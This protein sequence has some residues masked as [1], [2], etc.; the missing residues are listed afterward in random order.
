[1]P[2]D[3]NLN[4][5][6]YFDDYDETKNFHRILIKPT[7][8]VQARELNQIQS[9]LQNQIERFGNSI[10]KDGAVINGCN[11]SF[12]PELNYVRLMDHTTARY[13]ANNEVIGTDELIDV[14]DYIGKVV[15]CPDTGLT[16]RILT[17]KSGTQQNFPYTNRFYI[18]YMNSGLRAGEQV[19][20]FG[21]GDVLDIY[22]NPYTVGRKLAT[23][24]ALDNSF[25]PSLSGSW[26]AGTGYGVASGEGLIYQKGFFIRS[27]PQTLV[28]SDTVNPGNTVVGFVTNEYIIDSNQ[29][30]TLF[31]NALGYQNENA[32][33]ADRMKLVANLTYISADDLS[34][35]AN[36]TSII[37]YVAG[38]PVIENPDQ[39]YSQIGDEM[40][41]RSSETNG[42]FVIKPFNVD[43][44]YGSA[45]YLIAKV[46]AGSGYS[47]GS[48]VE[49]LK[50]TPV[51]I[52]R[53]TD[54][55]TSDAQL[56]T[57]NYGNYVIVNEYAG[58]F[59]FTKLE[60]V[61]IYDAPQQAV[62]KKSF[63]NSAV[64][65]NQ[66]GVANMRAIQFLTG[67]EGTPT[68]QHEVYL[69]N[70]RMNPGKSFSLNGK[71]LVFNANG[72]KG[73]ADLVSSDVLN[74][75]RRTMIW[76]FGN[77]AV[78]NLKD[79]HNNINTQYVFRQKSTSTL[80]SNGTISLTLTTA[81][82]GG[83]N[84]FP[85]GTG[86]TLGD[87]L[88]ND[89]VVV[90]LA[91][92][93][94][95][96]IGNVSVTAATTQI[97]G[98][99]SGKPFSSMF[100]VGDYVRVASDIRRVIG[101]DANNL[102]VDSGF[103]ATNSAA[104]YTRYIQA[105]YTFPFNDSMVGSRTIQINSE[106]QATLS[107][108]TS[109]AGA[110][111]GTIPVAVYH[112][113]L[114]S[115]MI[116]VKKNI[117]KNY[118]VKIDTATHT[119]GANG[120]WSMG[121]TDVHELKN[122]FVTSGNTFIASGNDLLSLFN[123]D[124]GQQD[125]H[126]DYA[127]LYLK[128]G[129]S[130]PANSKLTVVADIFQTDTTQ[131][132]GFYSIDSYPIDDANTANTTAITT[133]NLPMYV[134]STG[135]A[136]ALRDSIDCRPQKI[137]V[138]NYA[139]LTSLN[140]ASTNPVPTQT[141]AT[142]TV[143]TYVPAPDQNFETDLTYYVGRKDIVYFS[144][145]GFV[146]VKEGVVNEFPQTPA[147]PDDGMGICVIQIPPF[148]SL[149]SEENAA[150]SAKNKLVYN[151]IRDTS[152]GVSVS[153]ITNKRYRMQDIGTID[154]RVSRLEYYQALN[155]LEQATTSLQV[156]DAQGLDRFKNGIFVD[157]FTNFSLG[158]VGNPE[159]K[160][161][162]DSNKG[163][164]RPFYN[165][166]RPELELATSLSSGVVRTG[167]LVTLPYQNVFYTG[168]PYATNLRN[169]ASVQ[170][171]WTGSMTLFPSYGHNIDKV[172]AAAVQV[173]LDLATPWQDFANSPFGMNWGDWRV[174]NTDV[175][176]QSNITNQQAING[177]LATTTETTTTTTTSNARSG[178][179]LNIDVTNSSYNLGNYVQDI[180]I[181]PYIATSEIAF[182]AWGIR[183]N[184]KLYATFDG[185]P[186]V[187]AIA[188]GVRNLSVN[189]TT[190]SDYVTRTA[191]YGSTLTSDANGTVYGKFLIPAAKFRVG[192][193][194]LRLT[195]VA[196]ANIGENSITTAAS[197][198]YTSSNFTVTTGSTTLSTV[199]PELSSTDL[200]DAYSTTTASTTTNLTVNPD[201]NYVAPTPV[202]NNIT[203]VTNDITNVTN[204]TDVTNVTNVTN[205]D[206]TSVTN[207]YTTNVT[208]VLP[209][210]QP[211]QPEPRVPDPPVL[212]PPPPVVPDTPVFLPLPSQ[213]EREARI[214]DW[215]SD[216]DAFERT[217]GVKLDPLAQ[218]FRIEITGGI[219]GMFLTYLDIFFQKK[220]TSASTGCS[221]YMTEI[222]N[223]YPDNTRVM[224]FS[225]AH[226]E[227]NQIGTS[228][229]GQ[230]ATR[231]FFD[232]PIYAT[233]GKQ[234]A[235]VVF[236]DG[237]D[238]DY[239]C[240]TAILGNN[241]V[242]SGVQVSSKPY[243]DTA[244][245]SSNQQAWSALQ[246]EFVKF[247]IGRA[248]FTSLNGTAGFNAEAIDYLTLTNITPVSSARSMSVGDR[249][250]GVQGGVLNTGIAGKVAAYDVVKGKV[251]VSG[252]TGYFNNSPTVQIHRLVNDT[253]A[254]SAGS[255]VATATI[256]KVDNLPMNVIVP[257]FATISPS[258]T[259]L[260]PAFR[261][262]DNFYNP[263]G[264]S[265]SC[266]LDVETEMYDYERIIPSRSNEMTFANG[267]KLF[268]VTVDF[269]SDSTFVSPVIDLVR[270]NILAIYNLIDPTNF[271]VTPEFGNNGLVQTKYVSKVVTLANGQDA[272]DLK[273]WLTAYKPLS[274]KI[275]VY[276][277]FLS[278]EDPET[279]IQKPWTLLDIDDD[280]V[281]S[282][283][284]NVNDYREIVFTVPKTIVAPSPSTTAFV[285][286]INGL[287]YNTA[288]AKYSSYKAFQLK[289]VLLSDTTARVPRLN[290]V[291]AVALQ[292]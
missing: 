185:V 55:R 189:D 237:G 144:N 175:A 58:T 94:T 22:D 116:P 6:P 188:P 31:D 190:S 242:N 18:Q 165:E 264:A 71:S 244:F 66:I 106:T 218:A 107:V 285:D 89:F 95:A 92:T 258:G 164:A 275:L 286:S 153:I 243:V 266:N 105:G 261:G 240:W 272:E 226:L 132:V 174:T 267:A 51:G 13:D 47:Q 171:L 265:T 104:P 178:Q 53:G 180:S 74:G 1:M 177:V 109:V 194:I 248:S 255:L 235:F 250:Y 229:D 277:K 117:L 162:I 281:F 11:I 9:I 159:F 3:T 121:W 120:P 113:V 34:S 81:H 228:E 179:K 54:T 83:T 28:I 118:A 204:I 38:V 280:T 206:N 183:P 4:V 5:A 129:A 186:V 61:A 205:V 252:T 141:F 17:I 245:Y 69:F 65:G 282:D 181:Q 73:F 135:R 37:Q 68:A 273:V 292:L 136:Y 80:N 239:V 7:T 193:R 176:S 166:E 173:S 271:N 122:V 131:G 33:G 289:I 115:N 44:G 52:R 196:R 146:K 64:T 249:I 60:E 148:P 126:Y 291:R 56:I 98:A 254:P 269:H 167:R 199:N 223:G 154:Q 133:A 49:L 152:Y 160:I 209:V 192:E 16:A 26:A 259:S 200:S 43:T 97:T 231:F 90:A 27:E 67:L 168:Q 219:S 230:T 202:I 208:Q 48:R 191:P 20:T 19:Q 82:A 124:T 111:T 59:D 87:G 220:S 72:N 256:S 114:R 232:S 35:T 284:R 85:Y 274:S 143:G 127:T 203:N 12:Y 213:E 145:R 257:R 15:K 198:S 279:I 79:E 260:K 125:T 187:E 151:K 270:S 287:T 93:E 241:D 139:P 288:T 110:L 217:Y 32:P 21:N 201:P 108:G 149:S 222:L 276:G 290:D 39:K 150:V 140:L 63:T 268:N 224:P 36:F 70:I 225:R 24:V 210:E 197:A 211:R 236:P 195:D 119:N 247:N 170:H 215:I 23:A 103:S 14:N 263:D 227:W 10:Y 262:V 45:N 163:V 182:Y 234:Y 172:A 29:D 156:P 96:V 57:T 123:F 88:E 91:A 40:N 233:N 78:K 25:Y 169:A 101:V 50:T 253:D 84:K 77:R 112:N 46:S 184:T 207:L 238:P 2:L 246:N 158:D 76:G 102:V 42:S 8:A 157:P 147:Q 212:P 214:M 155:L 100:S 86:I 134:S 161:A 216:P 128:P 62:S 142:D 41:R 137:N 30:D 278:G 130:I 75:E 138:A 283:F 221:V 251:T 99:P